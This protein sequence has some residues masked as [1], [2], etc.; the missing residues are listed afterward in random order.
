[1]NP[2]QVSN[3]SVIDP[4]RPAID[5]VRTI[6]FEPFDLKKWFIIGFC[7]WLAYL[8]SGPG[9]SNPGAPQGQWE[10]DGGDIEHA[11][12]AV[13]ENLT[14]IIPVAVM[15][16]VFIIAVALVI[17]WLSSRGRF[18]F[19]HCV[20]ENKAEVKIPWGRFRQHGNS[21]F[22]FR[23]ILGLIGLAI[24]AGFVVIT[25]L[26]ALFLA[27]GG[28]NIIGVLG[29]IANVLLLI[30][31]LI[32][33]SVVGKFTMDFVVP[34]MYL[35]TGSCVAGWRKFM[36]VLSVNKARLLLYILFQ[37]L[38]AMATGAIVLAAVCVT[39]C[40]A[41]CLLAIPY[42]GTVLILPLLVFKRSYSLYYLRQ[43]GPEF[44]VFSPE[45]AGETNLLTE[46]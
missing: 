33:L 21:L 9:G 44:D 27:H 43:F 40:C 8:G 14:W 18:M 20:A 24:V 3:V 6:L 45:I 46:S 23:I 7:A 34:V 32:A 36:T 42:I 12:D 29:L 4:I 22:I 30:S 19:L 39:C 16:V 26:L 13:A 41:A 10:M 28:F 17:T 11:R 5:R 15:V 38:I 2:E 31:L 1:M 37:I 25:V 35:G